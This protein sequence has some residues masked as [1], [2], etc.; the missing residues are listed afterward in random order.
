KTTPTDF[1][2]ANRKPLNIHEDILVFYKKLPTYNPQKTTGH[3]RKVSA[4]K[5]KINSKKT[6]NY[7]EYKLSS[8]D[9]T[10]RYPTTI[11]NFATDKQKSALHSTQ[12]PIE[13]FKWL[14]KTYTNEGETVLRSEERRV[15]KE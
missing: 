1:L 5:H 3:N 11:L 10:E 7:G 8:Y 14:I 2:N 4:S 12:K 9:S 13:L 15:G 6:E